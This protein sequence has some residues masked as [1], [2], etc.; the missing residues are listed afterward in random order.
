MNFEI[1]LEQI[2]SYFIKNQQHKHLLFGRLGQKHIIPI[3]EDI[4]RVSEYTSRASMEEIS[5][6]KKTSMQP[7]LKFF[8]EMF[9][10]GRKTF[11]VSLNKLKIFLQPYFYLMLDIFFR[12][13]MPV[14]DD[15]SRDKPNEY[16]SDI[17]DCSDIFCKVNV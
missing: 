9:P 16:S 13:G 7:H 6:R 14:Y 17:E 15:K 5:L 4:L 3:D 12:D 10:D 8:S 11:S 1:I 2:S